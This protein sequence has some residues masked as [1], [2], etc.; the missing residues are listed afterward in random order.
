M[1]D[2]PEQHEALVRQA[3][4]GATGSRSTPER[5]A[6]VERERRHAEAG[7]ELAEKLGS[8]RA[9]DHGYVHGLVLEPKLR[10]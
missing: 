2:L 6:V 1:G 10:K 3:P 9:I 4:L 8:V 7:V 5:A